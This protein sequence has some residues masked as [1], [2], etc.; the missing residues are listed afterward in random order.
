LRLNLKNKVE[1][2]LNSALGYGK[3]QAQVSVDISFD[4]ESI[5][6]ETYDPEGSAVRSEDAEEEQSRR[7]LRQKVVSPGVKRGANRK[8]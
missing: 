1:E 5:Q 2:L 7:G 8:V 6:E 4:K 3:A